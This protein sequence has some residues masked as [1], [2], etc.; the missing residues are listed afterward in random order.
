MRGGGESHNPEHRQCIAHEIRRG[1]SQCDT[2]KRCADGQ[3]H[4]HDPETLGAEKI[5]K[6]APE[7]FDYPGQ[8]KPAGIK[9]DLS[10][11]KSQI[12]VKHHAGSH[13]DHIGDAF[14]DVNGGNPEPGGLIFFFHLKPLGEILGCENMKTNFTFCSLVFEPVAHHT[15]LVTRY[16]SLFTIHH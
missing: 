8:I 10:I 15:P 12:L 11:G 13:G 16:S 2:G 9:G 4:Q 6:G 5:D 1:Q 3:L 7:G 14:G